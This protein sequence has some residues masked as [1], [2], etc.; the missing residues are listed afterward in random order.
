MSLSPVVIAI[1]IYFLL[2]GI[3]LIVLRFQ[4]NQSYRLNDAITNINLGVMSQVTGVFLKVLSIGVYSL[5]FENFAFFKIQ[6]TIWTFML[7]FFLYD[8]CY[9]WAHR[10]SHEIN[11]FWGGHVVHHSSEEY[12]LSVALRQ[13]STQTLWTFFFYLPLALIGFDRF[14]WS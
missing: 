5:V 3:E 7:L 8:F 12:N 11:L 2:M 13:S 10:M 6:N 1:P 9:Y 14:P 4:N